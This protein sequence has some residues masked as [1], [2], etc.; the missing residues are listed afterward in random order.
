MDD[1]DNEKLHNEAGWCTLSA[2]LNTGRVVTGQDTC[3]GGYVA[4]QASV[5]WVLWL[6]F[7]YFEVHTK[8]CTWL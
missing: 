2:E 6:N 7:L 3:G 5:R 1:Y 4:I 8:M